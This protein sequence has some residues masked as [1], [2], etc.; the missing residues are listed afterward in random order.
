MNQV[1]IALLLVTSKAHRQTTDELML[2]KRMAVWQKARWVG[3]SGHISHGG[4]WPDAA[5]MYSDVMDGWAITD[6]EW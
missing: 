6:E 3:L 2:H 5:H 1:L 4:W